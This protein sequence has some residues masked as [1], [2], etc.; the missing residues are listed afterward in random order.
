MWI[1]RGISNLNRLNVDDNLVVVL[2][3][4]NAVFGVDAIEWPLFMWHLETSISEMVSGFADRSQ[5]DGFVLELLLVL[6]LFGLV[7]SVKA[8]HIAACDFINCSI[9]SFPLI[10]E[11]LSSSISETPLFEFRSR[12]CTCN[13]DDD[14]ML[15]FPNTDTFSPS[16]EKVTT[17]HEFTAFFS[18]L[19]HNRIWAADVVESIRYIGNAS[20]HTLI[21]NW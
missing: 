5:F 11:L 7:W 19:L 18:P 2:V 1:V 10:A 13:V 3:L 16:L 15:A 8:K 9:L 21:I 17:S 14:D 4:S 12:W 20:F 6:P